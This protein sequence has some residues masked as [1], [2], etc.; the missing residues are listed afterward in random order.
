MPPIVFSGTSGEHCRPP[1]SARDSL[2]SPRSF[3]FRYLLQVTAGVQPCRLDTVSG[4]FR[5]ASAYRR[6]AAGRFL[7]QG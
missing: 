4:T 6:A 5:M 2:L 7:K 3:A 1:Y